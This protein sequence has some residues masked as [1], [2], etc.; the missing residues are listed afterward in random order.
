MSLIT[1]AMKNINNVNLKYTPRMADFTQWVVASEL[2]MYW[3]TGLFLK[4]YKH[5]N[6]V[7]HRISLYSDDMATCILAFMSNIKYWKGTADEL[8]KDLKKRFN[9]K[10]EKKNPE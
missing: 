2:G 8:I 7:R 10:T 3:K 6:K 1:Q 4:K 5:N 9:Q